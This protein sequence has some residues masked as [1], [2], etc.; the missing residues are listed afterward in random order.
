[1]RVKLTGMVSLLCPSYLVTTHIS[2]MVVTQED[3]RVR[4]V[5]QPQCRL[6]G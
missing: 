5:T 6:T 4:I 1:M 2:L 3:P